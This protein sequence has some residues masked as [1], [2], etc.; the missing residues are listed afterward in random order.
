MEKLVNKALIFKADDVRVKLG[1]KEYRLVY[2]L[3][4]FCE[5]E[6]FYGSVDKILKMLFGGAA[7]ADTTVRHNGVE[8]DAHTI[9]V[10]DA[11][12]DT[13]LVSLTADNNKQATH[14]DTLKLLYAGLMHDAAIYNGNDE[15]TGYS[16]TPARI[17]SLVTLKNIREINTQI[18]TAILRDLVPAKSDEDTSKNAEAP[19]AAE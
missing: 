7:I 6:K 11:T 5:L 18:V 3:N 9:T 19:D 14:T 15:I 2:D 17:G 12:L 1:D 4:A 10:G 8:I 13:L 16:L